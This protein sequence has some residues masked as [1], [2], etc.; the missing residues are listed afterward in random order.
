[1]KRNIYY[2]LSKPLLSYKSKRR[3]SV[4]KA[5]QQ[6]LFLY[7][8]FE[9]VINYCPSSRAVVKHSPFREKC[10]QHLEII[11]IYPYQ[12]EE[13]FSLDLVRLPSIMLHS[14]NLQNRMCDHSRGRCCE[15]SFSFTQQWLIKL[16][17]GE[18]HSNCL[19]LS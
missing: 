11:S 1:M 15:M 17:K 14:C 10:G 4:I 3:F 2:F 6:S 12:W 13:L 16:F 9:Q 19:H 18:G 7:I 8:F 5:L